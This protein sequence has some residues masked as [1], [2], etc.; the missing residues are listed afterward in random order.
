MERGRRWRKRDDDD[1]EESG[2]EEGKIQNT[3]MR[4]Q[5]EVKR[6]NEGEVKEITKA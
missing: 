1:D 3:N 4:K 6:L 5:K 2:M